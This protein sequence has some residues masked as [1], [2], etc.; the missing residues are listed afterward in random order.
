MAHR[1]KVICLSRNWHSDWLLLGFLRFLIK[2]DGLRVLRFHFLVRERYIGL[3]AIAKKERHLKL[4]GLALEL[5]LHGICRAAAE[6][7]LQLY[8]EV[9]VRQF[10]VCLEGA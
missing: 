4:E 7:R 10:V 5:E 2:Y 6:F 3:E 8:R 9:L 1:P